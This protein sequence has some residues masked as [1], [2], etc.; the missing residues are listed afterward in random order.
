MIVNVQVTIEAPIGRVFDLMADARN[1]ATWNSQVSTSELVSGEPIGHGT[2]FSTVNRGQTYRATLTE[3]DR[4]SHLGYDVAGKPLT[5]H[6]SLDFAEAGEGT[7]MT[8]TFDF[9][10]HGPMKVMLPLMAPMVRRDF[11]KQMAS[12]KAFCEADAGR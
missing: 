8:G 11:P 7:V 4:P 1:E 12:F 10:P 3:Y 6:G 2:E 5:I 9:T